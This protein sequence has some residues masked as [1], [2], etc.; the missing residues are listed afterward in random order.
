MD[1]RAN[2]CEDFYEFTCGN[3]EKIHPIPKGK[4]IWENF[5]ILQEEMDKHSRGTYMHLIQ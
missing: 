4:L 5:L 1:K 3:F 2:P